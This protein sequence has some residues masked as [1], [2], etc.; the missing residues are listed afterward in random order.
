MFIILFSVSCTKILIDEEKISEIPVLIRLNDDYY[1]EISYYH[2]YFENKI[3][4][5]KSY[6]INL[7]KENN[8]VKIDLFPG[9]YNIY[10]Y[11]LADKTS[12][13][14]KVF[15]YS[16]NK[17]IKIFPNNKIIN[18]SLIKLLPDIKLEFDRLNNFYNIFVNV[19]E[20]SDIF[21]LSSLSIKQGNA[22]YKSIDFIFDYDSMNYKAEISV[23]ENG[24][25][26]ANI[27][28][29]LKK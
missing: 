25:W 3:N 6:G 14:K 27:A 13:S 2:L 24:S 4:D 26:Y 21:S 22:R 10:V 17:E 19:R 11:G 5:K 28:Y 12:T 20:I 23:N 8:T 15:S 9:L 1:F 18:I 16:I 29:S 7:S